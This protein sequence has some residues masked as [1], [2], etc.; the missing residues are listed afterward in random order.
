MSDAC[1]PKKE[2]DEEVPCTVKKAVCAINSVTGT[3]DAMGYEFCSDDD[4]DAEKDLPCVVT[5][6]HAFVKAATAYVES[7]N[8]MLE[9]VECEEPM[10]PAAE[11][12][13]S[14]GSGG[15]GG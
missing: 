7:Q 10:A 14:E 4:P 2:G 6:G 8:C 5:A 15:E 11:A 1:E 9:D 3:V 12:C 13:A